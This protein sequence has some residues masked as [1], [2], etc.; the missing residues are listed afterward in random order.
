MQSF[1]VHAEKTAPVGAKELLA[2]VG[3]ALGFVPNLMGVLAEAPAALEAY[4]TLSRL[5]ESSSFTSVER[6]VVLLAV[7][8]ENGCDYCMAA[9][10]GLARMQNVPENL[11][12][13]LREGTAIEEPRLEA[14]R[15]FTAALTRHRA[16][17]S[18]AQVEAF[19]AAGFSRQQVL[20]VILGVT[21]KTLSNYVNHVAHT[22]LDS[23]FTSQRWTRPAVS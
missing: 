15:S 20:E 23:A 11:V 8:F 9:H 10:S 13:A 3:K 19:L 6:Q 16:R 5:F 14:L 21:Q 7:S 12:L 17:V 4:L 1:T 2:G 22:P 18:E